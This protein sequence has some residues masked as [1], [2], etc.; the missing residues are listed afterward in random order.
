MGRSYQLV[1]PDLI[2]LLFVG[3]VIVSVREQ[4]AVLEKLV[5]MIFSLE[6][7]VRGVRLVRFKRIDLSA[8]IVG[9]PTIGS[10]IN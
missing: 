10:R 8:V 6:N 2:V 4:D 9:I 3:I 7:K 5:V 1:N